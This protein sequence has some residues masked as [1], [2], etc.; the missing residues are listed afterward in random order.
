MEYLEK[1]FSKDNDVHELYIQKI[2]KYELDFPKIYEP[3]DK[4]IGVYIIK[5]RGVVRK[6]GKFEGTWN[7]RA[8]RYRSVCNIL[9][10]IVKG[11]RERPANGHFLTPFKLYENMEIGESAQIIIRYFGNIERQPD[12]EPVST[13]VAQVERELKE[14]Y[15]KIDDLWLT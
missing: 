2:G 8:N 12:G 15:S 10:D 9:E 1:V 7:K 4:S 14:E 5:V 11:K 3:L 6:V 13:N